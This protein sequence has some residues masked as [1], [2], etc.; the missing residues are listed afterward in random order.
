MF[1]S[2]GKNAFFYAIGTA[3]LRTASFVLIP[4]YTYSLAMDDYGLLAVLL[5]TAQIMIIVMSVG[6]RTAL[7]RFAKEYEDKNQIGI[8]LGTSTFINVAAAA[9]VTIATLFLSPLFGDVLQPLLDAG[10]FQPA[11]ALKTD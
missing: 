8:L 9:A 2:L 6:S 1:S 3:G 11:T 5:Q 10:Y 7:V 4:I